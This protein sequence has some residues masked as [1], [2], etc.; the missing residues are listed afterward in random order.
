MKI[1]NQHRDEKILAFYESFSFHHRVDSR[2]TFTSSSKFLVAKFY[3]GLSELEFSRGT[4]QI[5]RATQMFRG[6]QFAIH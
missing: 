1:E 2:N 5:T 3:Q 6:T 4:F